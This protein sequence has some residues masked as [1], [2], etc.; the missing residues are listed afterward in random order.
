MSKL[1]A[2]EVNEGMAQWMIKSI[3]DNAYDNL[4]FDTQ[5]MIQD[6]V[7]GEEEQQKALALVFQEIKK[8]I[9]KRKV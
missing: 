5:V 2:K 8:M 9:D 7:A 3:A 6:E 4:I 1:I